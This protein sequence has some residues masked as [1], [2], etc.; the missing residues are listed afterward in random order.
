VFTRS[1]GSA[2]AACGAAV[3]LA[4]GAAA[5]PMTPVYFVDL[6]DATTNQNEFESDGKRRWFVTP[7]ADV[8]Q[9]ETYERPT[10]QTYQDD[11][12]GGIFSTE[13]YF[14]NLDI[15]RGKVG[16]DDQF[17]YVAID[18]VGDTKEDQGG[19]TDEGLLYEYGFRFSSDPDGR[20]GYLVRAIQPEPTHGTTFGLEK[21]E[22]WMDGDG[23]VGGAASESGG[24]PT[25]LAVTKQDN[26]NEETDLDGY[27]VQRAAD[28]ADPA[29]GDPEIVWARID[30]LDDTIVEIAL[31]YTALG[32]D[33]AYILS[34]QYL[35]VQAIKGDPEDPANYFWNDKYD[36]GEA[37]SPNPDDGSFPGRSEFD[38]QGL[39]NIYELDTLRIGQVPEPSTFALLGTGLLAL[40]LH[41]RRR[42]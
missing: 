26:P 20:N 31:D 37:G 17:L 34:I 41:G 19:S 36:Q 1:H 2:A 10:I 9:T 25:G 15:E 18:L 21:N 42:A 32:L 3:L 16:Y 5:M 7:G 13:E 35:D 4:G 12:E 14:S 11:P 22:I 24:G 29:D 38:T 30:P 27:D 28:G 8:Y 40:G 39:G 6:A 33:L 23:D